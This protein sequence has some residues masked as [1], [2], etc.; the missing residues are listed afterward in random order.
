MISIRPMPFKTPVNICTSRKN[1]CVERPCVMVYGM[2][3]KLNSKK[4][5][6]MRVKIH[7]GLLK[8][9]KEVYKSL[10]K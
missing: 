10:Q 9:K 2:T 8:Y 1:N 5:M 7:K 6:E 3:I 4:K